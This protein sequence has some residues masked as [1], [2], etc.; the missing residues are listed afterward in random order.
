MKKQYRLAF[1][2]LGVAVAMLI[3]IG[4]AQANSIVRG[5]SQP[6]GQ[7]TASSYVSLNDRGQVSEVGVILSE[8]VLKDLPSQMTEVDLALPPQALSS[9]PFTHIGLNWNPQ[10][11][12]PPPIYGIPHFD[13][14]FYTISQATRRQITATDEDAA[15]AYQIPE[16]SLVPANYVMAPDSA[17]P[18]QGSHWVNPNAPEFQGAPH[19]FDHTFIYG[20]YDGR[21]SFLEPMI[22]KTMLEQ[23]QSF[24]EAIARPARY[25]PSGVYPNRYSLSY[26][27]QAHEYRITLSDLNR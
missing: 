27:A 23:H 12:L 10:G 13:L 22:S 24:D 8:S 25:S 2:A 9:T 7:G 19:G 14:H 1:L 4:T 11:H 20:F 21:M 17:E 16:A 3:T 15:K 6:I 26:D 18:G 5:A